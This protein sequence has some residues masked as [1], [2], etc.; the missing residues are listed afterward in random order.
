MKNYLE[1]DVNSQQDLPIKEIMTN[2]YDLIV[3][4]NG[5]PSFILKNGI[6]CFVI[7]YY[8][9]LESKKDGRFEFDMAFAHTN[10][11][12]E[13]SITLKGFEHKKEES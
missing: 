6:Q 4:K 7:P 1:F 3:Y 12:I 8:N 9:K 13:C 5:N 11:L 2:L 10:K